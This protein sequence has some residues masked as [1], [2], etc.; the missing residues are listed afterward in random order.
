MSGSKEKFT[1]KSEDFEGIIDNSKQYIVPRYQRDY[2]WDNKNDEWDLIWDDIISPEK[3]HY[4]GILVFQELEQKINIIDGQQRLTTIS[5]IIMAALYLLSE[6]VSN[7]TDSEEQS[8]AKKQL[9]LLLNNYIARQNPKDLKYY[10]KIILNKNNNDFFSMLCEI[11]QN[12]F[13]HNIKIKPRELKSNKIIFEALKF[14]YKKLENYITSISADSI[15]EFIDKN[16][17]KKL[18]FNLINVSDTENAYMLFETLN[19]RAVELSAYDLLKNHLLSKAGTQQESS[20]L[21]DIEKITRNIEDDDITRFIALDWNSRYIPKTPE[22]R[23]Y[24]KIS[25]TILDSKS[26][27]FYTRNLIKSSETYK[28]IRDLEHNDKD[29]NELLKILKYIPRI[30][31]HY[32]ILLSLLQS[33]N[34]KYSQSKLIEALLVLALR[35]NYIG[36]GQ[37]N[38]Q[39]SVYNNIAHKIHQNKYKDTKEIFKEIKESGIYPNKAE[40]IEKFAAKDFVTE[41]LDR[42]IIAKIQEHLNP[43]MTKIDYDNMTVEHIKDKSSNAK[44]KNR[45]GNYLL[46]KEKINGSLS[47]SSFEAKKKIYRQDITHPFLSDILSKSN[48]QELEVDER[49]RKLA[50]IANIVFS[51]KE[52]E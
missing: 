48:W 2:T 47:T 39:E 43:A 26:A 23:I 31:Q 52:L 4:V 10:G 20:M 40:F 34:K 8:N 19:S 32:M 16:I 7:S 17:N 44:Y 36:Q 50:E 18:I 13:I 15:I 30:K 25:N 1:S 14:F 42:Y 22:K 5:L 6:S 51:M 33:N 27:F 38:K 49:S 45:I 3:Q 11:N 41:K 46:L 21:E 29:I 28:L 12:K 24:R 35:Y 37:A 9:E